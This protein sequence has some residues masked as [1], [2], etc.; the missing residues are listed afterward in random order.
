MEILQRSWLEHGEQI[1]KRTKA[2]LWQ[3]G[4]V[5]ALASVNWLGQQLGLMD[6]PEIVTVGLGLILAQ[7]THWLNKNT[8]LF[9]GKGKQ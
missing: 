7:V 9:G 3:A 1:V 8:R 5:G 2:L 4:C 6:L